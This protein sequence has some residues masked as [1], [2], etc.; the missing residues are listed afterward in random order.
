MIY[1]IE[2]YLQELV[3]HHVGMLGALYVDHYAA[4]LCSL[5]HTS[6]SL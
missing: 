3:H 6:H 1:K 2:I 4:V 5:T